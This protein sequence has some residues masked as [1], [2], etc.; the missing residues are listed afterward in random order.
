[1]AARRWLGEN[2]YRGHVLTASR[3]RFLGAGSELVNAPRCSS[4]AT[5]HHCKSGKYVSTYLWTRFG[6]THTHTRRGRGGEHAVPVRIVVLAVDCDEDCLL[7]VVEQMGKG[8]ACHTGKRSCFFR[9]IDA[10]TGA[11]R[12]LEVDRPIYGESSDA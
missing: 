10:A 9:E 4:G 5:R 7:V 6:C 12:D 8:V 1:M 11:L 3:G 2:A